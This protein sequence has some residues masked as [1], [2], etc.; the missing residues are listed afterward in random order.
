MATDSTKVTEQNTDSLRAGDQL[1]LLH[2]LLVFL[3]LASNLG[4]RKT[5]ERRNKVVSLPPVPGHFYPSHP[6]RTMD[7]LY[8]GRN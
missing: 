7:Q 5:G 1:S 2:L 8:R 4:S 3:P 6:L